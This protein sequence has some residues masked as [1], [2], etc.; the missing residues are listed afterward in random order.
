MS[1][2]LAVAPPGSIAHR[3]HGAIGDHV[4][5]HLTAGHLRQELNRLLPLGRTAKRGDH[6]VVHA[7]LLHLLATHL[8][9]PQGGLP[10]AIPYC[11]LVGSSGCLL[12]EK[13]VMSEAKV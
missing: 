2:H 8:Q 9:A 3:G 5:L 7:H 10:P 11:D 1:S 6:L 13:E 4:G 12:L